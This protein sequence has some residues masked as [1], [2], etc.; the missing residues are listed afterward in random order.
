M[1]EPET[2]VRRGILGEAPTAE[3]EP[4]R[5]HGAAFEERH[6]FQRREVHSGVDLP[7]L[8]AQRTIDDHAERAVLGVMGMQQ[9]DR[10]AEMVVAQLGMR[11]Q[12]RACQRSRRPRHQR[13]SRVTFTPA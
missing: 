4:V 8:A 1:I 13:A 9:D 6:A 12:Q 2:D 7:E 5:G 10:L 11:N 3:R